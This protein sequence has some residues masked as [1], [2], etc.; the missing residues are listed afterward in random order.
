MPLCQKIPT[1]TLPRE[2]KFWFERVLDCLAHPFDPRVLG[3]ALMLVLCT[4]L[5]AADDCG[6]KTPLESAPTISVNGL[7]MTPKDHIGS[8][9]FSDG[10]LHTPGRMAFIQRDILVAD[11][12][13][14]RIQRFGASGQFIY[15]FRQIQNEDGDASSLQE[16]FAIAVDPRG[17]LY[18]S[19]MSENMIYVF[20]SQGG[21]LHGFGNTS[22]LR[23]NQPAGLALDLDGYLYVAD[24]GNNRVLKLDENG[25]RV[26]EISATE[27][28]L[29]APSHIVVG[30]EGT[31]LVLDD[32]G[33]KVYDL[34][35]RF[36]R[37]W[38]RAEGA[39]GF[40][41]DSRGLLYLVFPQL[42]RLG[43]YDP[44]GK[45]VLNVDDIFKT[46]VDVLSEGDHLFVSD[47]G[48]HQVSVW[49][50]K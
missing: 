46:P 26:L 16:P 48:M 40:T 49:I 39:S 47:A 50:L 19:D 35:G 29:R 9:G 27:G 5:S 31:V 1:P 44:T 42:G 10:Q 21:Y 12:R 17:S 37:Q 41:V 30:V 43:I 28:N 24:T 11:R 45:L 25:K 2:G 14:R 7:T 23:F 13:N 20:D 34:Y 38:V 4:T 15:T 18:V 3:I 32:T 33:V 36:Q 6:C 8:F 22:G